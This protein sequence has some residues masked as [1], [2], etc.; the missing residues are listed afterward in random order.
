MSQA[1]IFLENELIFGQDANTENLHRTKTAENGTKIHK[2][3]L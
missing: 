2:M 1:I 3:K